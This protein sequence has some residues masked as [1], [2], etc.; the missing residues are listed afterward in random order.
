MLLEIWAVCIL[1]KAVFTQELSRQAVVILLH[2]YLYYKHIDPPVHLLFFFF[3]L[4]FATPAAAVKDLIDGNCKRAGSIIG[5]V[6][7]VL[8]VSR[9]SLM[10][11]IITTH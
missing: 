3:L 1:L 9:I 8:L 11:M 4:F 7:R 10:V 6:G 2:P 5:P